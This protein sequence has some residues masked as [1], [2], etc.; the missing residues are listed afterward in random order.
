MALPRGPAAYF[1][2]ALFDLEPK[3]FNLAIE[4]AARL[5][6]LEGVDKA[7]AER[8]ADMVSNFNGDR[9]AA[10]ALVEP[11]QEAA[12][13]LIE[14]LDHPQDEAL[15]SVYPA[16]QQVLDYMDVV[17]GLIPLEAYEDPPVVDLDPRETLGQFT[18]DDT[19][20]TQRE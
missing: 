15:S 14:Q 6:E 7:I 1:D 2:L 20:E 12:A 10:L 3:T 13:E 9:A 8:V 17:E 4:V 19:G 5:S 11:I 18:P 16:A